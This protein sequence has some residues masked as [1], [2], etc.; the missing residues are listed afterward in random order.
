MHLV[1]VI[2][3]HLLH[4]MCYVMW[5]IF[6]WK[7]NIKYLKGWWSSMKIDDLMLDKRI[8]FCKDSR[9]WIRI[10]STVNKR[11]KVKSIHK[12]KFFWNIHFFT[13]KVS[14]EY[15]FQLIQNYTWCRWNFEVVFYLFTINVFKQMKIH[16]SLTPFP[17]VNLKWKNVF[18]A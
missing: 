13:L 3:L 9:I 5:K 14:L 6:Y 4:L 11:Y 8:K 16:R 15:E 1:Y 7:H 12:M 10:A 2:T 18:C 17:F